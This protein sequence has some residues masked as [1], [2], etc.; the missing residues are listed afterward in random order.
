[1]VGDTKMVKMPHLKKHITKK[2]VPVG[3]VLDLFI[4]KKYLIIHDQ[5]EIW[6]YL[7]LKIYR[8]SL[9]Q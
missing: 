8:I 3:D 7:E 9:L 5:S 2:T 1:M 6:D 4:F